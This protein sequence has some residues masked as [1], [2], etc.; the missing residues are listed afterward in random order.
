MYK[1]GETNKRLEEL[2]KYQHRIVASIK[3]LNTYNKELQDRMVKIEEE[4]KKLRDLL[5]T[6]GTNI[7]IEQA[8]RETEMKKITEAM[9]KIEFKPYCTGDRN[10]R[11]DMVMPMS[12]LEKYLV[13][14]K[15]NEDVQMIIV[16]N[17][18]KNQA[19]S[20]YQMMKYAS[21]RLE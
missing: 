6:N 10:E 8:K 4:N 7:I 13:F 3:E 9:E 21:P 2:E 16:E 15:V 11:I 18:L 14:K 17:S 1:M 5:N 12:E 19:A 20:W